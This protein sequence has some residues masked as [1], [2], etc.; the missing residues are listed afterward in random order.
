L[1]A[2]VAIPADATEKAIIV[3]ALEISICD[4]LASAYEENGGADAEITCALT[5][6]GG[7]A[8]R[9]RLDGSAD[10]T[11]IS[12]RRLAATDIEFDVTIEII[13]P[14][15]CA[16]QEE[17]DLFADTTNVIQQVV[18][19]PAALQTKFVEK[20]VENGLDATTY[21]ITVDTSSAVVATEKT[22]ETV[23][24]LTQTPTA[25]PSA[26]P[27]ESPSESPS[28]SPS[29]SM[30]PSDIPSANPSAIP[31]D[32]PSAFPS[33][34]PSVTPEA[35]TDSNFQTACNA[36]VSDPSAATLTYGDIKFWDTS[37]ITDMSNAF[38]NAGS[39]ND[40]IS[41]WDVE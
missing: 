17:D 1:A 3:A 24:A 27:S 14:G 15:T 35:L 2:E 23:A 20:V 4:T 22:T 13:C 36:W 21:A 39:F 34:S 29:I 33:S 10:A 25:S 31:S 28:A 12:S 5:A 30:E 37:D 40:D 32:A 26:S 41:A 7:T 16:A 6:L 8:L 18:A 11:T 38:E 19:T 9:R